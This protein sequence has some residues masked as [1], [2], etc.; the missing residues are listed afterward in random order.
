MSMR[1][2]KI[3]LL[4]GTVVVLAPAL[5]RAQGAS[6]M[7]LCVQVS[8]TTSGIPQWSCVPVSSSNPLPVTASGGGGSATQIAPGTGANAG[9]AAASTPAGATQPALVVGLSPNSPLPAGTNT[10]GSVGGFDSGPVQSSGAVAASSHAA[11]TSLGGLMTLAVARVAGGSGGV[12]GVFYKSSLGSTGQV[13]VRM[14][15]RQPTGTT[16]T[17]NTAF[18]GSVTDDAN[19]I[20]PPFA[21]TPAAPASTTG[22]ARTYASLLPGRVSFLTSGNAN[23]YAC[24][25]TVATD[26][27]D[28]GGTVFVTAGGDLN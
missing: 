17:D 11:G 4:A 9:V 10:L 23:L 21:L 22:D 14:W 15:D 2:L 19:L 3:A 12:S 8:N 13:V 18:V 6:V 28:E 27:V 24:V 16:C 20:L 1:K 7:Q 26:T 25:V 5:A